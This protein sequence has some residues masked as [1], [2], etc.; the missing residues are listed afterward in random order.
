MQAEVALNLLKESLVKYVKYVESQSDDRSD[1][2]IS[3]A[4]MQNIAN[5]IDLANVVAANLLCAKMVKLNMEVQFDALEFHEKLN[6]TSKQELAMALTDHLHELGQGLKSSFRTNLSGFRALTKSQIINQSNLDMFIKSKI[7]QETSNQFQQLSEQQL[8]NEEEINSKQAAL[9]S[10]LKSTQ[11]KILQVQN[12]NTSQI[13]QLEQSLL[14]TVEQTSNTQKQL[15]NELTT[16]SQQLNQQN[17]QLQQHSTQ[18]NNSTQL[19]TS[20]KNHL[21]TQN[22]KLQTLYHTST[23]L[24]E[25]QNE[26]NEDVQ[27]LFQAL[28]VTRE[29]QQMLSKRFGSILIE[30]SAVQ[31]SG[32]NGEMNKSELKTED[33]EVQGREK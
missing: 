3:L 9:T 10:I 24:I 17:E 14:D 21:E 29:E 33:L 8:K 27:N 25:T 16:V 2:L 20:L 11:A 18:L 23:Q 13:Q 22:R 26:Q 32:I 4:E 28:N 5:Q 7:K 19:T 1:I 30:Q 12:I 6:F 15:Q 31:M